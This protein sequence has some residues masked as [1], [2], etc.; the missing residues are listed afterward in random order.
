[1]SNEQV[2]SLSDVFL[3]KE[4]TKQETCDWHVDDQG[5]WPESYLSTAAEMSKKDQYGIN[6]WIALDEMP[7]PTRGSWR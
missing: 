4:V 6:A 5:F 2:C 3:A 7:K 1:M